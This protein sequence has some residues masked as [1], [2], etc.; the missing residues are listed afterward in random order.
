MIFIVGVVVLTTARYAWAIWRVRSFRRALE[1]RWRPVAEAHGLVPRIPGWGEAIR[2]TRQDEHGTL[3][4]V[5]ATWIAHKLISM[6]PRQVI[7]VLALPSPG[8]RRF[9][10]ERRGAVVGELSGR[11]WG[12]ASARSLAFRGL[13][14][15]RGGGERVAPG[16]VGDDPEVELSEDERALIEQWIGVREGFVLQREISLRWQLKRADAPPLEE[17]IGAVER[18]G[19][20]ALRPPTQDVA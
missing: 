18:L 2:L 19:E 8:R 20:L 1:P 7:V 10:P 6:W 5:A 11:A 13:L 16:V 14:P 4:V 17:A 12:L 15:K 3:T 9:W